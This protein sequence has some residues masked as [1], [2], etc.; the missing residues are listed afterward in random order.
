MKNIQQTIQEL[1]C[2]EDFDSNY[3]RTHSF[4]KTELI[5]NSKYL[6]GYPVVVNDS[7]IAGIEEIFVHLITLGDEDAK[8]DMYPCQN[9]QTSTWCKTK[10]NQYSGGANRYG[11]PNGSDFI[12]NRVEC[13]YR[14]YH[15]PYLPYIIDCVNNGDEVDKISMWEIPN[16]KNKRYSRLHI[17]YQDETIDYIVFLD[18]NYN[19]EKPFYSLISGYPVVLKSYKRRFD[20]EYRIYKKDI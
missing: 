1:N 16:K 19:H 9:H 5:E 4:F 6:N 11:F 15:L 12:A 18:I 10:C 20:K 8:F 7:F 14:A 17:R 13:V 3:E 2:K